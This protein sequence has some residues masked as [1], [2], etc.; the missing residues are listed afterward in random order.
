MVLSG[1]D[2]HLGTIAPR[3]AIKALAA[4]SACPFVLAAALDGG[5]GGAEKVMVR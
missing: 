2:L 5:G 1:R 3:K 4:T